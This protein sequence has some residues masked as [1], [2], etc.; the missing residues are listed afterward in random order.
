MT[1]ARAIRAG[2]GASCETPIVALS[3]DVLAVHVEAC[4]AAGMS[5]HVGKPINT[6][7]LLE[8]VVFWTSPDQ[9]VDASPSEIEAGRANAA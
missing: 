4:K 9:A 5:D 1:A 2:D 8:K 6:R 3:A 7:V